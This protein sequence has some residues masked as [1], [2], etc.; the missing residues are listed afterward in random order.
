MIW[1]A[2]FLV[3]V[4]YPYV[5]PFFPS[6]TSGRGPNCRRCC[7]IMWPVGSLLSDDIPSWPNDRLTTTVIALGG[8]CSIACSTTLP[9][10][11]ATYVHNVFELPHSGTHDRRMGVESASSIQTTRAFVTRLVYVYH[12]PL[13]TFPLTCLYNYEISPSCLFAAPFP[14]FRPTSTTRFH[15][16]IQSDCR[17]SHCGPSQYR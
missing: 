15:E 2:L 9:S 11:A 8:S 3:R 7:Q 17:E 13:N 14:E 6:S 12:D 10:N 16:P 1:A 4:G 5:P